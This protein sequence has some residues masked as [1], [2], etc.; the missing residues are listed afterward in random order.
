MV[1]PPAFWARWRETAQAHMK[2]QRFRAAWAAR[3][4]CFSGVD[5]AAFWERALQ[6]EGPPGRTS[7]CT[8]RYRKGR[9]FNENRELRFEFEHLVR[10]ILAA[11][12]HLSVED[13]AKFTPRSLRH[14]DPALV[15][16]ALRTLMR[17]PANRRVAPRWFASA[18]RS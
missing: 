15:H 10:R 9:T 1:R 14:T 2:R 12:L 3:R 17:T 5:W 11:H 13:A 18:I 8:T 4:N 7:P 16:L 6:T